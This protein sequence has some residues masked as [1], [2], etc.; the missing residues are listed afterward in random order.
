MVVLAAVLGVL[1]A[2]GAAQAQTAAPAARGLSLAEAES[3]ARVAIAPH[4]VEAVYCFR[5]ITPDRRSSRRRALCLVA[6]FDPTLSMSTA[7]AVGDPTA[8]PKPAQ[9]LADRAGADLEATPHVTLLST[10]L[11]CR[12]ERLCDVVYVLRQRG[13]VAAY[14]GQ[15]KVGPRGRRA[16]FRGLTGLKPI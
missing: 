6:R 3:A 7:A 9:A 11:L 15:I 14:A 4:E 8:V 13:Q 16:H 2:A 10:T 1:M 12:A 5:A